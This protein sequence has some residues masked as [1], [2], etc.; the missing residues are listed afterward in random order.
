MEIKKQQTGIEEAR[1]EFFLRIQKYGEFANGFVIDSP[2]KHK[3]ADLKVQEGQRL[4]AGILEKVDPIVKERHEAHKESTK[5]RS[6][7]LAP[8]EEGS[9]LLVKKMELYQVEV[10]R[11]ANEER[12]RLEKEA[13]KEHEKE[14]LKQAAELEAQGAS[15]ESI[16]AV[17]DFAHDLQPEIYIPE[18]DLRTKTKFKIGWDIEVL[19]EFA[20][21]EDYIIRTVNI[22]A[23]KE[24]V[25][26]K[27]GNI[28]IPGI[29][30]IQKT[31][32]RRYK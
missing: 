17:I 9:K 28:K 22:K 16:K 10:S 8:I 31:E 6:A 11:K 2:E 18:P 24:V 25:K 14:F 32:T 23:I 20:V 5:F 1:K 19:D 30:V 21:P 13:K 4:K 26:Q 15:S 3:E 29:K 12:E 27:K 7:C